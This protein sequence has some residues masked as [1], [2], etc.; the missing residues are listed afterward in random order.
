MLG[1]LKQELDFMAIN[2]EA[3]VDRELG[4]FIP[5]HYHHQMLLDEPRILGFAKAIENAVPIGGKVLEIGGGTGVLSYFASLKAERVWCVERNPELAATASK[6]LSQ[7]KAVNVE[8]IVADG[9]NY[10]PPEPVDVVIC[11]MLHSALLREKQTVVL[12]EFQKNYSCNSPFR[13]IRVK[14]FL[15]LE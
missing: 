5:L 10:L 13:G 12:A 6:F 4:Q 9:A 3:T 8:V 15:T 7:N 2:M 14:G 1:F 11:E